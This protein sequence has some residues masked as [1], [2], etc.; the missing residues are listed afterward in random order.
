MPARPDLPCPDERVP[1]RAAVIELVSRAGRDP[2][3]APGD[4]RTALHAVV[5]RR[6]APDALWLAYRGHRADGSGRIY[7]AWG[8]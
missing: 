8:Y 4:L 5:A 2:A 3:A 7:A 1:L 6:P